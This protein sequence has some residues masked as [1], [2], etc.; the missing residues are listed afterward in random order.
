[1]CSLRGTFAPH[2]VFMSFVWI[3]EQTSIISVF[4]THCRYFITET[5]CVYFAVRS[6]HTVY[7]CVLCGSENKQRLF[8]CTALTLR[9]GGLSVPVGQETLWAL[10]PLRALSPLYTRLPS[11]S[12]SCGPSY[13][14]LTSSCSCKCQ[15]LDVPSGYRGNLTLKTSLGWVPITFRVHKS[16]F[17]TAVNTRRFC[18]VYIGCISSKFYVGCLKF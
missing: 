3:W 13:W 17:R 1:V 11:L 4:S 16:G 6:A 9:G 14:K 5:E 8:H 2:S 12:I 18:T 15:E 7:L 10:E